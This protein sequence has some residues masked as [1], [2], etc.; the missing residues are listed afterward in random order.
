MNGIQCQIRFL[1]N[2]TQLRS[3]TNSSSWYNVFINK[4]CLYDFLK[5]IGPCVSFFSVGSSFDPVSL[6]YLDEHPITS[7]NIFKI[8]KGVLIHERWTRR[9]KIQGHPIL[10]RVYLY[11]FE[12]KLFDS[13][14]L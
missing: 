9:P 12:R 10:S 2:V 3:K 8:C 14:S 4:K 11:K 13:F 6:R 1:C 7:I 5:E